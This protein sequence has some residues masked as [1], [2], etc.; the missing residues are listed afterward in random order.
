[1][2]SLSRRLLP[3]LALTLLALAALT[4]VLPASVA[5]AQEQQPGA[6]SQQP[7]LEAAVNDDRS[8]DLTLTGGPDPWWFRINSWGTCTPAT[9]NTFDNIR[10]YAAGAHSVTAY[11]NS[12]CSSQIASVGFTIPTAT[13]AATVKNDRSVDLA[14]TG[15]PQN[16]WFRINPWGTCTPATGTTFDNI[17]GYAAGTHSVTA[18]SDSNCDSQVASAGFTIPTA[19]LA[20]TVS[21]DRAVSL[22]LSG[23]PANWWFR[24]N[25]WGT[26]TAATGTTFDNIRGYSG[27]THPVWAYSDSGCNYFFAA[28]S[29]T[30]PPLNLPA[31]PA[32][33]TAYRGFKFIDVEWTPVTGATGYNVNYSHSAGG[34]WTRAVSNLQSADYQVPGTPSYRILNIPNY[35]D[36]TIAV[37]AVNS[38][39]G[40]GWRN[41][42]LVPDLTA[43]PRKATNVTAARAANDD[44]TINVS[45]SICDVTASWCNGGTPVTAQLVNISDDGGATWTRAKTLT[46][47]TSGSTVAI[48]SSDV[49]GGLS[50]LKSYL[51]DVGI[52]T[53][54][55]TVWTRSAPVAA[56]YQNVTNL[57]NSG[58]HPS[59]VQSDK[60]QAS[61]F[62]TGSHPAGYTLQSVV[63]LLRHSVG[64]GNLVWKIHTATTDNDP[65]PTDTVVATLSGSNPTERVNYAKHEYSCSG[66]GCDLDP[67]TTYF[68]V[69]TT[70]SPNVYFWNV[71]TSFDETANPSNNGW[72]IG[73]GWER[74]FSD[75]EWKDWATFND[76]GKFE[77]RFQPKPLVL[78]AAPA[79]VTG[80]RGFSFIDAEWAAVTGATGYTVRYRAAQGNHWMTAAT[81]TTGTSLRLTGIP[82]YWNYVIAVQAING[83]G[84]GP[85]TES[86]PVGTV[87]QLQQR[88][89]NVQVTRSNTA[90]QVSWTQCDITRTSCSGDTPVTGWAIKLS[91]DGGASWTRAKDLTTY[92]SGSTV[93]ISS[94]EVT[95]GLRGEKS[96][97]VAV[98][99]KTRFKTVWTNSAPVAAAYQNVTN[100][101][102]PGIHPA[103]V[104]GSRRQSAAFT[105][106]SHPAGYTVQSVVARLRHSTG[107]GNFVLKIHTAT[108][109]SDPKPT[110]TVLATLSG[111]N[112]TSRSSYSNLEYTC[113]GSGCD[114]DPD[115]T[116]FVVA[117]TSSGQYFWNYTTVF[118]ETANPSNNGWSIGK[119]WESTFSD[120]NWGDW[121]TYNDVPKFEVRFQ[122]KTQ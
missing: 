11:S 14:L 111:S 117:T 74:T 16:W 95:G 77:V 39:G 29:F 43:M 49:T 87:S 48:S 85:W 52:E 10:G 34:G 100:L 24:I 84:P 112:P 104:E 4:A 101:A 47:Y 45:W 75:G 63:T 44:T 90:I 82:N 46:T 5:L 113:S 73:K 31:A 80:Y 109:D 98:G 86:A 36:Y 21:N 9:G 6:E 105:T 26:C 66:S 92:T 69:A 93:T 51:L 12:N 116:Y 115:T 19:T 7:T 64:T 40:G 114:L 58:V 119:G 60:R 15:G 27:G 35:W 8:V 37:Q 67:D 33:V 54:F 106:G 122:P 108:T 71:T 70:S 32:T 120:G 118:T 59:Y 99:V 96:Y 56:L 55:K 102:N 53:R 23:G 2:R 88:A 110:D 28:A 78:P 57:A 81:E 41:S 50:G 72:S 38:D 68:L 17:R 22:T 91:S 25:P 13:L 107:S 3:A 97:L 18:Y 76:V 103:Y 79:S 94:S 61:A 65:T 30:M 83:H 121:A 62:T 42:A 1:M 89:S 20:A